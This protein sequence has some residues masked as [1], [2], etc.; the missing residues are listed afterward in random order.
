MLLFIHFRQL[1]MPISLTVL[2][3]ASDNAN[4]LTGLDSGNPARLFQFPLLNVQGVRGACRP[5][6]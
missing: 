5:L 6:G 3:P 1:T 4:T 2:R